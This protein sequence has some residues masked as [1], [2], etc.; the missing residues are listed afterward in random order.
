MSLSRACLLSCTVIAAI[1]NMTPAAA[2]GQTADAAQI[3]GKVVE[4]ES[5][6]PLVG[7]IIQVVGTRYGGTTDGD[8]R[9]ALSGL[10]TGPCQLRLSLLGYSGETLPERT[11]LAGENADAGTIELTPEAIRLSEVVVTPGSYS[12][13]GDGPV[14]G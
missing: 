10:P 13:M 4:R 7:V 3:E 14:R 2:V 6:E 5:G 12:I 11:L 1:I 8:G 9:F